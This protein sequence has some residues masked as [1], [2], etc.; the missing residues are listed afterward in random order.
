MFPAGGQGIHLVV[1][2]KGC[3]RDDNF[4]KALAHLKSAETGPGGKLKEQKGGGKGGKGGKGKSSTQGSI[5]KIVKMVMER[6]YYPVIIFAFSKK[7][8]ESLANQMTKLD[9]SDDEKDTGIISKTNGINSLEENLTGLQNRLEK[10]NN[11]MAA[12]GSNKSNK[13]IPRNIKPKSDERRKLENRIAV[14]K[15]REDN[16]KIVKEKEPQMS[17]RQRTRA[18]RNRNSKKKVLNHKEKFNLID[19]MKNEDV[20]KN[21]NQ[22]CHRTIY[23][24]FDLIKKH[25]YTTEKLKFNNQAKMWDLIWNSLIEDGK[26]YLVTIRSPGHFWYLEIQNR[27]FRILSLYDGEHNFIE[28]SEKYEYGTFHSKDYKE[29]FITILN[30]LNGINIFSNNSSKD[31][32]TNIDELELSQKANKRLFGIMRTRKQIENEMI[33]NHLKVN[34][35][36]KMTGYFH[37]PPTIKINS[38]FQL[39]KMMDDLRPGGNHVGHFDR[40]RN[41]THN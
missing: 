18:L 41:G 26:H 8:V 4:Q 27:K 1:D 12:Q 16:A 20:F 34:E 11:Q 39:H 38:V 6:D 30:N 32:W 5:Y 35:G 13:K 10:K 31:S 40:K 21:K 9:H 37:Q 33:S 3:F 22:N 25:N 29:D 14:A 23:P 28:Y 19:L 15:K 2:E 7:D 17:F 24:L 36:I